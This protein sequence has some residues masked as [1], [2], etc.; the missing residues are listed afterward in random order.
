MNGC[1]YATEVVWDKNGNGRIDE[2]SREAIG[3]MRA[4]W[5][6]LMLAR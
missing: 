1:A 6:K 3:L 5:P 4:L 2:R